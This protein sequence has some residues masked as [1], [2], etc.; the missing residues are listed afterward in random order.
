[1][2]ETRLKILLSGMIAGV[3]RQGGATWAVL[4]YFLGLRQLGHDVHFVEAI[5][6]DSVQP[7][8]TA[9]SDSENAA[10]FRGVMDRFG[11]EGAAT[12]VHG[13]T[14][15]TLGGTYDELRGFAGDCDVLV[16]LSGLLRDNEL[17]E[18]IPLRM[19][20]DLDPGFTQLWHVHEGLDVGLEGHNCFVTIGM[21]IGASDCPVPTGG[22]DWV[23]T[24]QPVVLDQ[25]PVARRE[26]SHGL[27]TVAN[28]RGY[29]SV[30]FQGRFYGQ[31]AHS[32]RPFFKLP[33]RSGEE[34]ALALAIHADERSDLALLKRHGWRLLDPGR[35]ADTPGAFRTFVQESRAEFGIAKSGYVA[36]NCGWFSDR[37]ICYLASGRPVLAQETGFSEFLPT[38]EG[39]LAFET[40]DDILSCIQQLNLDYPKHCR[41]A[42][43]IA[44]ECFDAKRVLGRLL[45]QTG[46]AP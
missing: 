2:T 33:E 14:R 7:R 27:T 40:E 37:S 21:T 26:P 12:L 1:M 30:D 42:R 25:W 46:A 41:A 44:E 4:Q 17:I 16:N 11:L 28:W 36:A 23:K 8:G 20:V 39:L 38:G 24:L 19:Y 31:K 18:R 5:P 35:V 32:L 29:G 22:L 43:K 10:Y 13:R 34:M 45:K 15:E 6:E 3:P 9:L